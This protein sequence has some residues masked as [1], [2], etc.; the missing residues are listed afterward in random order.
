MDGA[1]AASATATG[2]KWCRYFVEGEWNDENAGGCFN[3]P[4]WRVNPQYQIQ[5][6]APTHALFMLMQPDP[7]TSGSNLATKGGDEGGPKYNRALYHLTC[8]R[9]YF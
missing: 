3:F 4:S 5:T 6:A 8:K 9:I 2:N 7:R 1:V